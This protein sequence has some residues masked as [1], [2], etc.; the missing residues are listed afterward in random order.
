MALGL[1]TENSSAAENSSVVPRADRAPIWIPN[2]RIPTA[3][4]RQ[5]LEASTLDGVFAVIFSS[6]T[7]GVLLSNF[8]V[9]LQATPFEIGILASIP[10]LANFV[11]PLGAWLGDRFGSRHNY[12]AVVYFPARLV[13]VFLLLGMGLFSTDRID[14]HGM[15]LWTMV[16]MLASHLLGG[17]GSAAWLSWMAA[18]VPRRLRGRYF[19]IRNSAANLTNLLVIP[20]AGFVV[21]SYPRGEVEGFAIALAVGIVAGAVSL[22]F[23]WRMVDVTP[24]GLSQKQAVIAAIVA[25]Q[26][27][28][29]APPAPESIAVVLPSFWQVIR[30]DRN[31]QRFLAYF[32]FWMFAV[33]LSNPFFNLYL[34]QNLSI[35]ISWVTVY[36]SLTA[37]A[38]LLLLIPFGR[39][40]DR[41]GNRIPLLGVGLVIAAL[42]VFWLGT[43]T[44]ALS[45]WLWLPLLHLLNGG[46]SAAI[47]L[48]TNNLQLEV[49]HNHHQAK[50]FGITAAIAGV[51]GAIGTMVGGGLA[52]LTDFGGLSS[53]FLLSS[54]VRLVALLPLL[55][56][57]E[58][59][60]LSLLTL[61]KLKVGQERA[62]GAD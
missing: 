54:G 26:T 37:G 18:L 36:N 34:L 20:I 42:P 10:M 16:V 59:R 9:D 24:Q 62:I 5:S 27:A 52:Q 35:D 7:G 58:S 40:S 43:G 28:A 48:C 12:C 53:V 32:S 50:Y 31:F 41:I 51:T 55:L 47:D 33:N 11:Q 44:G 13:W 1:K 6:L 49:S 8:L 30:A 4:V 61:L 21:A 29:L 14:A 22:A 3:A 46:A 39:L 38:N 17:L 15:V 23:Q 56:I 2:E 19:S 45:L 25:D 60:G 57:Q